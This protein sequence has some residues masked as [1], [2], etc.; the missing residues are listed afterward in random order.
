MIYSGWIR[1]CNKAR[2]EAGFAVN[3]TSLIQGVGSRTKYFFIS[4][5]LAPGSQNSCS[6]CMLHLKLNWKFWVI[7]QHSWSWGSHIYMIKLSVA[8]LFSDLWSADAQS[9]CIAGI[10]VLY[11]TWISNMLRSVT[12]QLTSF[13]MCCSGLSTSQEEGYSSNK[14]NWRQK[15]TSFSEETWT[16]NNSGYWRGILTTYIDTMLLQVVRFSTRL[17]YQKAINNHL[18]NA[19]FFVSCYAIHRCRH[20]TGSGKFAM[21]YAK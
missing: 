16:N 11:A 12:E 13:C 6:W 2:A 1:R 15:V 21:V 8:L 3:H 5:V 7:Y 20:H 17:K 10:L 18:G 14:H 4:K 19:R 9:V